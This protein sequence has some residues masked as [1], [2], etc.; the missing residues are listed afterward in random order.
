[1]ISDVNWRALA[2]QTLR[3]PKSAAAEIMSWQIPRTELWMA[4]AVVAILSTFMSTLSNAM[5]PVPEPIA[6]L[7]DSPFT[8]FM[9]IAGGFLVTVHAIFWTGRM[10]GGSD[11]M[12][13]LL[14]L[15]VWMQVLR[16]VAQVLILLTVL[17]MPFL[18][19]FFVLF[20]GIATLWVFLNFIS[21][22]LQLNSLLRALLVLIAG[23]VAMS[24]GFSILFSMIGVSAL[25]VP[26]NV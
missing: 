21:V 25:G 10:L 2:V 14:A 5:M 3:D 19:S 13:D 7:V 12:D 11:D 17:L 20:V 18:A 1:M 26:A 15:L 8:L 4:A 6:G 23:A 22:G 9:I 24:L 16:A